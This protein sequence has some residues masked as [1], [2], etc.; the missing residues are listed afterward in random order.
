M[1]FGL[2]INTAFSFLNPPSAI[3]LVYSAPAIRYCWR[4]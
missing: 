2:G 1:C 3:S 4:R